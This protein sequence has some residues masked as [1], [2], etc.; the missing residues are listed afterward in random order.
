MGAL[1][2]PKGLNL[3]EGNVQILESQHEPGSA[4]G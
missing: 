3:R 1:L 2:C 4:V